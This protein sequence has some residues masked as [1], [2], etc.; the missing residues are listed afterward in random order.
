MNRFI[1]FLKAVLPF[2]KALAAMTPSPA[3]DTIIAIL[4]S[5][6]ANPDNAPAVLASMKEKG[7]VVPPT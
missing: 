6:L 4:E 2:A 7:M 1:N 5:L 3:D